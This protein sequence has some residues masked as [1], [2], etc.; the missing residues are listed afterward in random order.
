MDDTLTDATMAEATM[1]DA[2]VAADPGP[3]AGDLLVDQREELTEYL[4][5][6]LI[7]CGWRDQVASR[8]RDLIQKRGV[9]H[10]KLAHLVSEV[11]N[12]A[13]L[14]VPDSVKS[15]LLT[16]IRQINKLNLDRTK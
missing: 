14:K 2:T 8:C 4:R 1:A 3:D 7:E 9:E 10:V 6:R 12:E 5:S 15:D 11:K 13:K 16:K